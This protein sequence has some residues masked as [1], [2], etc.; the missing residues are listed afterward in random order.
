MLINNSNVSFDV[1]LHTPCL[2]LLPGGDTHTLGESSRTCH[3]SSSPTLEGDTL[4]RAQLQLAYR[5]KSTLENLAM[6]S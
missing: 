4:T 5:T 2:A 3:S 6:T 1:S